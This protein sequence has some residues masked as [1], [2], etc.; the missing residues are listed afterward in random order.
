MFNNMVK[1]SPAGI[2][3]QQTSGDRV[4]LNML[5]NNTQGVHA[6]PALHA[7]HIS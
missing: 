5:H 6:F 2:W 4:F 3:M 1:N 7:A